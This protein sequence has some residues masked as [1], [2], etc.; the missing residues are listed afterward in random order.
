MARLLG[1]ARQNPP[2]SRPGLT[3][4]AVFDAGKTGGHRPAFR[5][6]SH[7][8][9]HRQFGDFGLVRRLG[10]EGSDGQSKGQ[11]QI[12]QPRGRNPVLTAFVLLNL[13]AAD[14]DQGAQGGLRQ[15]QGR[16]S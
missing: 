14:P 1:R 3:H 9:H 8:P 15:T 12:V 11:G 4:R 6:R 5:C 16:A 10:K 7:G 13:L 2:P